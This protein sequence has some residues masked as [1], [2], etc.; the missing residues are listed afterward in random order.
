MSDIKRRKSGH[1][2][3]IVF[4]LALFCVLAA[5]LLTVVILGADVYSATV[6][7]MQ[8]NYEF[9]TSL[10]YVAGKLRQ[11]DIKDGVKIGEIGGVPALVM[12]Q[13]LGETSL[14]TYIYY[15]DGALCE[16]FA[17][18]SVEVSP[19]SGQRIVEIDGFKFKELEN[20]VFKLTCTDTQGETTSVIA[21]ARCRG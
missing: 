3:D 10:G 21:S 15:Y 17:G 16:V 4:T 11:N 5:S 1:V 13:A 18:E 14:I 19:Q 7:R 20:G 9:R 2:I 12:K 8:E 6:G